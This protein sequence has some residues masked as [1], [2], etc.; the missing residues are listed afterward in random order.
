MKASG[1]CLPDEAHVSVGSVYACARPVSIRPVIPDSP[2][3][4]IHSAPYRSHQS[5]CA[6]E[7]IT[8]SL[9]LPSASPIS[10]LSA[11]S[12]TKSHLFH[13][14]TA[15]APLAPVSNAETSTST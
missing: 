8:I 2:D 10:F 3:F 11:S 1:D 12:N 5:C 4:L 14:P 7:S 9:A 15:L 13:P 6:S